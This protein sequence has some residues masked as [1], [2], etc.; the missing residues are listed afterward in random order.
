MRNIITIPD[1]QEDSDDDNSKASHSF[2]SYL[3]QCEQFKIGE[4][5]RCESNAILKKNKKK[6]K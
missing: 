5:W 2:D 3:S 6:M 1:F 4:E